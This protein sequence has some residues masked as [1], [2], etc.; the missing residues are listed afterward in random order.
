MPV[1]RIAGTNY[2]SRKHLDVLVGLTVEASEVKE[3]ITAKDA[4]EK[5]GMST[6]NVGI[7]AKI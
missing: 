3:W 1:C 5:Y 7:I 4:A 2:Y 6:A